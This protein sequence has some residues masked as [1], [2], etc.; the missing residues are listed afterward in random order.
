[1]GCVD[2]R[3]VACA[4]RSA[5]TPLKKE[6]SPLG[7]YEKV[8]HPKHYNTSDIE[9]WDAIIAWDLDFLLG[10]VVKYVARAGRKPGE[11]AVNDLLKARQYLDKEI[12]A[13]KAKGGNNEVQM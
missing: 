1:M 10:N 13:I 6:V 7:N 9:V 11:S 8:E 12:D 3:D 2:C 4:V 5:L